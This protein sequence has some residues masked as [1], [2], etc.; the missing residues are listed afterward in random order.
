MEGTFKI[1][2]WGLKKDIK[3]LLNYIENNYSEFMDMVNYGEDYDRLS[4]ND[5]TEVIFEPDAS[6]NISNFDADSIYNELCK[7]VPQLEMEASVTYYINEGS[8]EKYVSKAGSDFVESEEGYPCSNC[9]QFIS[10][11]EWVDI[12]NDGFDYEDNLLCAKCRCSDEDNCLE[13]IVVAVIGKLENFKTQA[14]FKEVIEKFGGKVAHSITKNV[15][16]LITDEPSLHL[17]KIRKAGA[18]GIEI[19]DSADFCERYEIN[20]DINDEEYDED[21]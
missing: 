20:I 8:M 17:D 5:K 19:V 16:Y 6:G 14:N 7:A 1:H 3:S 13:G 11:D 4:D 15:D 12:M 2:F 21:Y 10:V 9:G 18:L